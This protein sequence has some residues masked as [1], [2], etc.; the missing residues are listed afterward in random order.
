[1]S[2]TLWT[3]V[4]FGIHPEAI[5]VLMSLYFLKRMRRKGK[6]NIRTSTI[7]PRGAFDFKVPNMAAKRHRRLAGWGKEERKR[8]KKKQSNTAKR[9]KVLGRGTIFSPPTYLTK[10]NFPLTFH[11]IF[12]SFHLLRERRTIITETIN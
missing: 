4:K 3:L 7:I 12:P 11:M 1:V 6:I 9:V 10:R 5:F 2:G 8:E